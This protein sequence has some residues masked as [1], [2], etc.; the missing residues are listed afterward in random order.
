MR[1]VKLIDKKYA[2]TGA[3]LKLMYIGCKAQ[4][5]TIDVVPPLLL[6]NRSESRK[7]FG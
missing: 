3:E 6:G 1:L 2:A 7:G 4:Y 5:F